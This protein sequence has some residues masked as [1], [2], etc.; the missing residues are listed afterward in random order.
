MA[1]IEAIF[2]DFTILSI[3]E[4]EYDREKKNSPTSKH[5]HEI[6]IIAQKK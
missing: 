5:R 4:K 6:E 2:S 3:A 1:E